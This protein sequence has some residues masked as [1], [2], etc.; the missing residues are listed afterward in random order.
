MNTATGNSADKIH[1][2]IG[3][4]TACNKKMSTNTIGKEEFI[5]DLAKYPKMMC[6]KCAQKL[7]IT[8]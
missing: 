6:K 1:Y 8:G 4:M 5:N 3:S 7:K 2:R